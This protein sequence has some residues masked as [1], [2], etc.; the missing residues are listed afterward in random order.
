MVLAI[1]EGQHSVTPHLVVR[2]GAKSI[3]FYKQA[4]G[5]VERYRNEGPGGMLMHAELQIGDSRIFLADAMP[6]SARSPLELKG[7]PVIL[8]LYVNGVDALWA[9]AVAAGAKVTMPLAN[10][11]W[12]DRYGQV[13][14]PSGHVWALGQHMEDLTPDEIGRRAAAHFAS[15]PPPKP[16]ARKKPKARAKSKPRAKARK[17]KKPARKAAKKK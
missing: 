8:H 9:R 10:Q 16:A 2:G 6:G 15:M 4:F 13:E 7:S 12:G 1:P 5:A 11:F 17:A 14:D 3:E